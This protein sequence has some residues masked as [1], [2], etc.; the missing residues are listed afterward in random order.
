MKDSVLSFVQCCHWVM[1]D[2]N[3]DKFEV[4]NSE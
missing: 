3:Y 1:V 2:N 4:V